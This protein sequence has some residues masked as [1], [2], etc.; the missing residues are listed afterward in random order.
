MTVKDESEIEVRKKAWLEEHKK[1]MDKEKVGDRMKYNNLTAEQR[2]GLTKL[3]KRVK[4]GEIV[5][6]KTDKSGKLFVSTFDSYSSRGQ[7]HTE[8]DKKIDETEVDDLRRKCNTALTML[9][10]SFNIGENHGPNN[11][12][13]IIA[14]HRMGANGVP[15]L[16]LLEKDHKEQVE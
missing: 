8:G 9:V 3:K 13:R 5:V 7:K 6:S 15:R 14:S 4:D 11:Q 12:S 1:Y 2:R 16:Y 10:R